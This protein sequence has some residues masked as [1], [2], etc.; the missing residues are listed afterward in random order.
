MKFAKLIQLTIII[1]LIIQY[2]FSSK[3]MQKMRQ[4]NYY[5][6]SLKWSVAYS[7]LTEAVRWE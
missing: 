6:T 4:R 5:Q 3:I 2:Y 1:Q 7:D